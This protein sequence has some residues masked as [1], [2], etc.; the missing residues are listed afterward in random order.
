MKKKL[1]LA[2]ATRVVLKLKPLAAT[3]TAHPAG[4]ISSHT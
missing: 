3:I 1:Y 2:L 4:M